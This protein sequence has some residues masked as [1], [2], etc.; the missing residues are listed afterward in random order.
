M[1]ASQIQG[2]LHP[3]ILTVCQRLEMEAQLISGGAIC[4]EQFMARVRGAIKDGCA[5][6]H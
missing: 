2:S 5:A 3:D 6:Q 1:M 4:D